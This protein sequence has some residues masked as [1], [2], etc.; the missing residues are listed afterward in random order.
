MVHAGLESR[1]RPTLRSSV[2]TRRRF[3]ALASMAGVAVDGLCREALG[4]PDNLP[5]GVDDRLHAIRLRLPRMAPNGAKVPIVVDVSHPMEPDHYIKRLEVVNERDP[6]PL[7]G[8]FDFGPANGQA[9]IAFQA[10][11]DEGASE[12]L[13]TA[14]CT[15]HGRWWSRQPITIADGAGGCASTPLP[16]RTVGVD[17]RPPRIHIPQLVREGRIRRDELIDVQAIAHLASALLACNEADAS[18]DGEVFAD[19]LPGDRQAVSKCGRG[20]L[21]ALEQQVEHLASSRFGYSRDECL[22]VDRTAGHQP[23]AILRCVGA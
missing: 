16:A 23:A 19:S 2:L 3:L 8:V 6:I 21:A 22:G 9:F 12:V 10:R 1:S 7:K 11:M 17:I 20:R 15:R 18:E 13:V 4:A 14:E 5:A